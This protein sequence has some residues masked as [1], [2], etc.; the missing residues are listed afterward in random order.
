MKTWASPI[1]E[2]VLFDP[3]ISSSVIRITQAILTIAMGEDPEMPITPPMTRRELG[4]RIGLIGESR[5]YSCLILAERSS[6]LRIAELPGGLIRISPGERISDPD[7]SEYENR[8]NKAGR[9][10]SIPRGKTDYENR[11]AKV[12]WGEGGSIDSDSPEEKIYP[13]IPIKWDPRP[14]PAQEE[15]IRIL[16][17]YG[18]GGMN[19]T[20]IAL[21]EGATKEWIDLHMEPVKLGLYGLGLAIRKMLDGDPEPRICDRCH[22]LDGIHR[23]GCLKE[24]DYL[25]GAMAAFIDH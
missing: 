11:P 13:P 22:G 6:L 12:I 10:P 5:F 18:V 17:G 14:T 1:P 4:S 20:K 8:P 15:M 9:D 3:S 21:Q 19:R 23:N 25:S 16:K 2:D 7:K 24:K